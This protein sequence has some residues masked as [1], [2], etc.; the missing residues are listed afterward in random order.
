MYYSLNKG[1]LFLTMLSSLLFGQTTSIDSYLNNLN[2][3]FNNNSL[4]AVK[5]MKYTDVDK[6]FVNYSQNLVNN[7]VDNLYKEYGT[8]IA[9]QLKDNIQPSLENNV[10]NMKD[11]MS[12]IDTSFLDGYKGEALDKL[13]QMNINSID[14]QAIMDTI[15]NGTS[16]SSISS[17][18]DG[19]NL[20]N[21]SSQFGL[22]QLSDAA[23]SLSDSLRTTKSTFACV[24]ASALTQAFDEF[25]SHIIDD[26]LSPIYANINSLIATVK[27]NTKVLQAKTP[28]VVK[29]NEAYIAKIIEAKKFLQQLDEQLKAIKE[30][31][32]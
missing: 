3:A 16:L 26:N 24:C 19:M 32:E 12:D 5:N 4:E 25:Q 9:N 2:E 15:Q 29:S 7:S 18:L 31:R 21:F 30:D 14:K 20:S 8:E 1:I 28:V 22:E 6:E 27:N 10:F 17:A 23:K 11:Y 13:S